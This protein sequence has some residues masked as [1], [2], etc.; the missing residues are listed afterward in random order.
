M[1]LRAKPSFDVSQRSPVEVVALIS[2]K[3][4]PRVCPQVDDFISL[5]SRDKKCHLNR[6]EELLPKAAARRGSQTPAALGD[7][8]SVWGSRTV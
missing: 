6:S 4:A 1:S 2:P 7:L 3:D 5:L 8:P